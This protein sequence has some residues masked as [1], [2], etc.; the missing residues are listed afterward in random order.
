VAS[1][2]WKYYFKSVTILFNCL[3][4]FNDISATCEVRLITQTDTLSN[5]SKFIYFE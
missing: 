5:L 4:K 2:K 1:K 3:A